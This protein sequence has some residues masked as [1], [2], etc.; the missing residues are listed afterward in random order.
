MEVNFSSRVFLS[1][2]LVAA[3]LASGRAQEHQVAITIDDLPRGGDAPG[4][5]AADRAMTIKL[6]APFK[7]EQIALTGFVNECRHAEE[8]RELL[9]LWT[10]A[11]A[12]LGNH[13]CSH[14]DLNSTSI[15]DF[16]ADIV[17]G[18]PVTS[19]VLGRL[20][21][22]FRYPY[23]HTGVTIETR[24]AVEAFVKKRGYVMAPVTLD[25]E[26][27]VF[28]R[29][30]A[31][32]LAQGN[33]PEAARVLT[34]YVKYMDGIC[35]FFERWGTTVTGHDVKQILLIHANQLNADAMPQLLSMLRGRG[36]EFVS[37]WE[38]LTDSAYQL[39]ESYVG[40]KGISWIHRWAI[41]KGMK[42]QWEPEAP[43]WIM[44]AYKAA[45]VR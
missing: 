21:P 11:G 8:V 13:T 44:E 22:Y 18:E 12:E 45:S 29:V 20:P 23:L 30:Y 41:E 33:A 9:Q 34:A 16:E 37:T 27:Y 17:K 36:Y 7:N 5:P 25:D 40:D 26:D 24:E 32:K 1:L 19:A 31:G 15:S 6:L 14:L 4:S 35:A 38:A 39:P 10:A 43:A 28:A 42:V 3:S 2:T